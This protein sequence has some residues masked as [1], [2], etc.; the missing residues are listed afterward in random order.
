MIKNL[1]IDFQ[2]SKTVCFVFL[3]FNT[4]HQSMY[5]ISLYFEKVFFKSYGIY[6]FSSLNKIP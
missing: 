1:V 2:N 5:A 6:I 3:T 4:S